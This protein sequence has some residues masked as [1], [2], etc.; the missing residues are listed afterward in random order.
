MPR[1]Y[2]LRLVSQVAPEHLD[3]IVEA[4][5]AGTD[6]DPGALKESLAQLPGALV[7]KSV[8]LEHATE[9]KIALRREGV[10]AE[11]Q[12]IPNAAP[13]R[14]EVSA[15][16]VAAPSPK[17]V[18][19]TEDAKRIYGSH[20]AKPASVRIESAQ[21][22]APSGFE[23]RVKRLMRWYRRL[24]PFQ[25]YVVFGS[26][27]ILVGMLLPVGVVFGMSTSFGD[28]NPTRYWFT[29]ALV[30]I[31]LWAALGSRRQVA[32]YTSAIAAALVLMAIL[33]FYFTQHRYE[34]A[35]R[36]IGGIAGLFSGAIHGVW[37]GQLVLFVGVGSLLIGVFLKW[38]KPE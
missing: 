27:L 8:T 23:A 9:L 30:G 21:T 22:S 38:P 24:R 36:D 12:P 4:V 10:L 6:V 11:L 29:I 1:Y 37:T 34:S 2:S 3:G 18:V 31:T 33:N 5:A 16:G 28:L 14:S 13:A 20:S 19:A 25:Q 17:A 7:V 32:R 15:A 26:A 35:L